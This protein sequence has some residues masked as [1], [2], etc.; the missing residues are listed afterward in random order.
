MHVS[1][2]YVQARANAEQF[3]VHPYPD[4]HDHL[5]FASK[6]TS[7]GFNIHLAD[8]ENP[9]KA[10]R[11][12]GLNPHDPH[13]E[14]DEPPI[15]AKVKVTTTTDAPKL[16]GRKKRSTVPE[17]VLSSKPLT[18][19]AFDNMVPVRD[20][21]A[22]GAVALPLAVAA[23][24]M[25][26]FNR[27]QIENLRGELFQ[28]KKATRRLFEVVQDFS[29]NFVGL[30]NSFNELR[31]LLFSLVLA[32]PTLLDA[33]LSRIENQLRDRLRRVTHAIQSAVHQRFA[34]DYL[35][36]AEMAELFKKLEERANEA[37]CELLIQYHSDLFQIETSLL[38]DGQDAHLLLHVP[39]TPKNSLLRLFW[40][41]PF[42]LPMFETHHLLPNVKDNV[43]AISST[44]T[45]FNVQLSSTDLMSCHRVNQIFM[46]DSFGVMSKRFNNRCLGALYMQQFSAAQTLCP[47]KVV[48]VEERVYQLRKGHFI[49]YLPGYTTVNIQCR[50]GTASEMHLKKGT[51]QLHIP[52]G[53]QGV[54]P[55]HLVTSDWSVRLNDSIIHYEWDW[56]PINFLPAG[57]MEQMAEALKHIGELRL[58]HPDLTDL[59]YLTQLG[60]AHDASVLGASMSSW[61]FNIAGAAFIVSLVL[62][63]GCLCICMCKRLCRRHS[64]T[65]PPA[66]AA[67]IL[68]NLPRSLSEARLGAGRPRRSPRLASR[69]LPSCIK[70]SDEPEPAVS[71]HAADEEVQ[72]RSPDD[73]LPDIYAEAQ[74]AHG[75]PAAVPPPPHYSTLP[76]GRRPSHGELSRRLSSLS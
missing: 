24:A 7:E 54:F 4:T 22:L 31:S 5:L 44:D 37:G 19:E 75:A 20:K 16:H 61:A 18:E 56:D 2:P 27:A 51:Q 11:S 66:A 50:D 25:G 3:F 34:V 12:R 38:Y 21:R 68:R 41:H 13:G 73:C 76:R 59:Q 74:V 72:L 65:P 62:I 35:N 14:A 69:F 63:T 1:S 47:F 8:D 55:N 39:M 64:T 28:Q 43:L 57:E 70:E 6:S 9:V 58:H 42:P 71:Y 48:P 10:L 40:L 15:P 53:C 45:R 52:P 60:S 33:R 23:T 26:L 36:P 67:A 17:P 46:C 29:Q 30:Q 32:N 49:A